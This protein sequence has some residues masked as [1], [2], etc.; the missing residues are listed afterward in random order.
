MEEYDWP[1]NVREIKNV[2][3]SM[4]VWSSNDY[5]QPS[6]LPWIDYSFKSEEG[7]PFEVGVLSGGFD[8]EAAVGDYEKKL[9][10]KA[11]QEYKTTRQMA[12]ALKIDQSTVVRKLKKYGV[13]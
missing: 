13:H 2:V 4:F 5:L 6:D 12:K 11:K 7:G 10:M 8:L 3:E 9:L 1:G